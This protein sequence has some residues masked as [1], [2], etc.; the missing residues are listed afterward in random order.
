MCRCA[1]TGLLATLV[2]KG[3]DAAVKG[4]LEQLSANGYAKV[5]GV[6]AF[7]SSC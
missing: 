4:S 2:F 6:E 3:K 7:T 5:G 1:A